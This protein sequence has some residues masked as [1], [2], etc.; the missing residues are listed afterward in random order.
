[1]MNVQM[2]LKVIMVSTVARIQTET[3]FWIRT[4]NVRMTPV[5]KKTQGAL[6]LLGAHPVPQLNM[7]WI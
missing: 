7:Q 3:K 4:M 2:K 1:M 5:L 6:T